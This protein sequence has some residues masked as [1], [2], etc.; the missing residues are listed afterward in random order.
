MSNNEEVEF[1][2]HM[3]EWWEANHNEP[4]TQ[5]MRDSLAMAKSKASVAG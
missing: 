5:R 4:A 2:T 1:W 3:I